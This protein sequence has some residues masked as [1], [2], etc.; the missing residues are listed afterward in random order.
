M[1]V[2]LGKYFQIATDEITATHAT[3][4]HPTET[5][6]GVEHKLFVENFL[7]SPA[8]FDDMATSK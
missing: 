6:E 4:R 7:F 1:E 5:V 8:L 2:Y 3:V